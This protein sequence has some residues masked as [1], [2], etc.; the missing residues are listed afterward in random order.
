M[1]ITQF[2]FEVD[3]DGVATATFDMTS[4]S[5]NVWNE[6]AIADFE[7]IRRALRHRTPRSRA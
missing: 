5:M 3:A 7:Q 2:R 4:K 1:N 6:A